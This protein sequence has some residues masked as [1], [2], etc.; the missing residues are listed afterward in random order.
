MARPIK[1]PYFHYTEIPCKA[2]VM[3]GLFRPVTHFSCLDTWESSSGTAVTDRGKLSNVIQS[4]AF[5]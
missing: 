5:Y 1:S 4:Y 3:C 2:A